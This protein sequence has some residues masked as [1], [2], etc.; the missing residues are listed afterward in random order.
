MPKL[1]VSGKDLIK[2]LTKIGF[3]IYSHHGSHVKLI[4]YERHAK[5]IVPTHKTIAPGTL[6]AI[7]KQSKV[8]KEEILDYL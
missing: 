8:T 6:N 1:V 3:K 2:A 4:S 5:T 7:L